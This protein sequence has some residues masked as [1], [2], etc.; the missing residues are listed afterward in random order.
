LSLPESK[1]LLKLYEHRTLN[2]AHTCLFSRIRGGAL[3]TLPGNMFWK[4]IVLFIVSIKPLCPRTSFSFYI[5]ETNRS[6]PKLL[7]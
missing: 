5:N 1:T 2:V 7:G 6:A 3:Y 4:S